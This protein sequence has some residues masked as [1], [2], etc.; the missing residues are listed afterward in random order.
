MVLLAPR[1][2]LAL[3]LLA[4]TLSGPASRALL[5][6]TTGESA[7]WWVLTPTV[8]DSLGA[9]A[10]LSLWVRG[11][12]SR[13]ER[14]LLVWLAGLTVAAFGAALALWAGLASL[15]LLKGAAVSA[16]GA[17]AVLAAAR[18][19]GGPVGRVLDLAPLRYIG[20]ISY[21]IYVIHLFVE[22][23]LEP[24]SAW[25]NIP[26]PAQGL[27]LLAA[28]LALTLPLASLSWHAFEHPI[29]LLKRY[30]P[31]PGPVPHPPGADAPLPVS[32]SAPR[33]VN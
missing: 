19:I 31:Y 11:E 4:V 15:Y 32:P 33:Q 1:R 23:A 9:G 8:L 28:T 27:P 21:G 24:L 25:L 18:G 22:W 20:T 13:G 16:L 26:I 10:L 2:R 5:I 14:T 7:A 30:V 29:N 12:L 6:A 3:I 17:V